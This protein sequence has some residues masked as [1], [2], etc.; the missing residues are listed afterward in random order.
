M[1]RAFITVDETDP[2][3]PVPEL[4]INGCIFKMSERELR[5]LME[6]GQWALGAIS[7]VRMAHW[8]NLVKKYGADK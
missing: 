8:T 1:P 3:F 5:M 4:N 2:N 7:G 6:E